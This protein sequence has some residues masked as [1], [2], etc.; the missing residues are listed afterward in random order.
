LGAFLM[1]VG[2]RI[3]SHLASMSSKL[4][5]AWG[6]EFVAKVTGDRKFSSK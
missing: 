2:H 4:K 5:S 6:R 1:F 3:L